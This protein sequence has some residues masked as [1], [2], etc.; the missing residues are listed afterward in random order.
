MAEMLS[1]MDLFILKIVRKK[2][3]M[4]RFYRKGSA[5][6]NQAFFCFFFQQIFSIDEPEPE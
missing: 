1:A 3:N 6:R 4:H 2:H 5:S